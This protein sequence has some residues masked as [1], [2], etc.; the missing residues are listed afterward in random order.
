MLV[1]NVPSSETTWET[2]QCFEILPLCRDRTKLGYRVINV[3]D[4][5][6]RIKCSL[7]LSKEVKKFKERH[8]IID[9]RVKE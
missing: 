5:S 6:M 8:F 2:G 7:R 1:G 9:P 4:V 3:Q